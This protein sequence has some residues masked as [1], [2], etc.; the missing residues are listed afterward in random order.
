MQF[1]QNQEYICHL[2]SDYTRHLTESVYRLYSK[3]AHFKR[4]QRLF[5]IK[6][7]QENAKER[8]LIPFL[9]RN[10]KRYHF[11]FLNNPFLLDLN[12]QI[13]FIYHKLKE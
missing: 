2:N 12:G 10:L 4:K 6:L 8:G 5:I 3:N 7:I 11:Y 9:S 1:S 13:L